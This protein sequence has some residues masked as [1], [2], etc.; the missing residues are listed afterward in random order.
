MVARRGHLGMG[1]DE[2]GAGGRG[3]VGAGGRGGARVWGEA[4]PPD[5]RALRQDEM[6]VRAGK[7][8]GHGQAAR[9]SGC[10]GASTSVTTW[11]E[12]S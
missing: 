2:L 5:K 11:V 9:V 10:P 1:R 12:W 4:S 3:T 7:I 8:N 6:R